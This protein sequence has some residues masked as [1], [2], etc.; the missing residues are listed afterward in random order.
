LDDPGSGSEIGCGRKGAT[1]NLFLNQPSQQAPG[2]P[3]A[4]AGQRQKRH[5]RKDAEKADD[6]PS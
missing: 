1:L 3:V 6:F 2:L 4:Y 5:D